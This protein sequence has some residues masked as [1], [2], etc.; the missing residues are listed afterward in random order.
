MSRATRT[1]FIIMLAAL[2]LGAGPGEPSPSPDA[3]N[4]TKPPL[5][6]PDLKKP[7]PYFGGQAPFPIFQQAMATATHFPYV[8]EWDAIDTDISNMVESVMLDKATPQEA[9]ASGAKDV[10]GEFTT[11]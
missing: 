8:K 9:L 4:R 2:A 7:D 6:S 11:G 3:E 5:A 10:N 1:S